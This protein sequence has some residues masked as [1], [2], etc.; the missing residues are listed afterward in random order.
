MH[1]KLRSHATILGPKKKMA[2]EQRMD[3]V[4]E[5]AEAWINRAEQRKADGNN[6]PG[7][8]SD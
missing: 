2:F 6:A 1:H 8:A 5:M 4:L 3:I 7:P